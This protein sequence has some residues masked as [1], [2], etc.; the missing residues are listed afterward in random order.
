MDFLLLENVRCFEKPKPIRLAPLTILVGEN[1]TGK[2][3]FL[4]LS[5][6]AWDIFHRQ[7]NINFNEDPYPMGSFSQI[8]HTRKGRAGRAKN[9]KIGYI[10]PIDFSPNSHRGLGRSIATSFPNLPPR[11]NVHLECNFCEGGFQPRMH[12]VSISFLQ[13]SFVAKLSEKQEA[14][15]TINSPD[16]KTSFQV[17]QAIGNSPIHTESVDVRFLLYLAEMG[18]RENTPEGANKEMSQPVLSLMQMVF[19]AA[20][21]ADPLRP[22]AVAPVRTKP[23]RTYDPISETATPDGDHVPAQMAKL[24]REKASQWEK[25]QESLSNFGKRSQLFD[26]IDIKDLGKSASDPFQLIMGMFGSRVNLI[27]VGYGVSQILPI[28]VDVLLTDRHRMFLLQQP[29]VHL[30]PRAQAEL[31]SIF[32]EIC[33][34][35]KMKLLVETHSDYLVDRVRLDI[36]DKKTLTPADVCILFF[37][38]NEQHISIHSIGIDENG[39]LT[40]VPDGFRKFFSEEERRLFGHS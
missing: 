34:T 1:S 39:N 3:S 6:L 16:F 5:R 15:I 13:Y 10:K 17:I 38:R 14:S 19:D 18:L 36:R 20:V 26:S 29:E 23:V 7:G 28:L 40:D 37:E 25:L 24:R 35:K 33:K 2:T 30:H 32:A 21:R 11:F 31:G 4:A 22:Y 12:E 9:F 27:D 8:A